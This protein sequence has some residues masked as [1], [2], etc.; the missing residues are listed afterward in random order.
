MQLAKISNTFN[1][2]ECE[3]IFQHRKI[4]L[5]QQESISM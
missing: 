1:K 2:N 4:Q 5:T 3:K